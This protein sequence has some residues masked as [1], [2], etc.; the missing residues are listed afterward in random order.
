MSDYHIHIKINHETTQFDFDLMVDNEQGR[1]KI[2]NFL[3]HCK[4]KRIMYD[5][6]T[7]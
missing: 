3:K 1:K 4:K 6:L 2:V 5:F 7:L